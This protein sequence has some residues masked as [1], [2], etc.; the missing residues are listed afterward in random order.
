MAGGGVSGVAALIRLVVAWGAVVVA[1]R[2]AGW[3]IAKIGQPRVHGEILAGVVLGPSV[4]GLVW[5]EA[6]GC[7][8]PTEVMSTLTVLAQVG[9]ML[10]MFVT[11]LDLDLDGL[12]GHGHKAVVIS[13]ASV[14]APMALGALLALWLYPRFGGST[15]RVGFTLFVG[16]AMS[17]TAFPVLARVLHETRLTHTQTGVL[18]MLG[19]ITPT[20]FTAMV[21]MALVTTL[22]APPM[23]AL[24][25][26]ALG[27]G[28]PRE[29]RGGRG[30]DQGRPLGGIAGAGR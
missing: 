15:D 19:I 4:L 11:G 10:F 26:P 21:L 30:S 14:L 16:A 6:L 29:A 23:L 5:P 27:R 3:L 9:L 24:V 13:Q 2:A 12:R 7:L 20:L 22:M 1:A 25:V 18:A 28:G 8:F 17:V